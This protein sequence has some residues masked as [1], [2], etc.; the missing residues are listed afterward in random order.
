MDSLM[1]DVCYSCIHLEEFY[2]EADDKPHCG[3]CVQGTNYIPKYDI[4]PICSRCSNICCEYCKRE[5]FMII[6]VDDNDVHDAV[7][8][9]IEKMKLSVEVPVVI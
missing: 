3:S 1:Y 9:F 8:D 5:K 7:M 2:D 4:C 6:R